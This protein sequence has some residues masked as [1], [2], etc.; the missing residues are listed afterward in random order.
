M[1]RHPGHDEVARPAHPLRRWLAAL[2]LALL[3]AGPLWSLA[4]TPRPAPVPV[5][6]PVAI[7]DIAEPHAEQ[8]APKRPR[9]D[10]EEEAQT[11][12]AKPHPTGARTMAAA[13]GRQ[14]QAVKEINQRFAGTRPAEQLT[15]AAA[16]SHG[17]HLVVNGQTPRVTRTPRPD[18]TEQVTHHYEIAGRQL[19]IR[20]PANRVE[21][22][23]IMA[24]LNRPPAGRMMVISLL[25]ERADGPSL[26]RLAQQ[27]DPALTVEQPATRADLDR[28]LTLARDTGRSV[29]L[30]G[31][32]ENRAGEGV[33]VQQDRSNRS[34]L[35]ASFKD[36]DLWASQ[37][38]VEM[39]KIGCET[40]HAANQAIGV[41]HK[42]STDSLPIILNDMFHAS[43]QAAL[44][45]SLSEPG[46]AVYINPAQLTDPVQSVRVEL[47]RADGEVL[48][49]SHF[50]SPE[51]RLRGASCPA[52][53]VEPA[54][55]K[56]A[57]HP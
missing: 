53:G 3:G 30:F 45:A 57:T 16:G 23:R 38:G 11:P 54:R 14:V 35:E 12:G 32:V 34:T 46:Q 39:H 10:A 41:Q 47:R 50:P 2:A 1:R 19:A 28:L 43:T 18:G 56:D 26:K 31:H 51:A 8:V 49:S 27:L 29:V 36:L 48:M 37:Q 24:L 22:A 40:F 52:S 9:A 17:F 7:P 55:C 4:A 25:H 6:R 44:F 13:L 15:L 42:V 20:Q 33:Y 5:N 21:L